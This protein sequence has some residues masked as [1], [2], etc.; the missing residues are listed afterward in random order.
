[1][2]FLKEMAASIEHLLKDYKIINE[3]TKEEE[4]YIDNDSKQ[5]Y[6]KQYSDWL[7]IKNTKDTKRM[8]AM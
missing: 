2:N 8:E 7:P 3:G 1:M 4:V 6:Q 5:N